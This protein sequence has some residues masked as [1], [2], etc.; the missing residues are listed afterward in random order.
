MNYKC[1]TNIHTLKKKGGFSKSKGI[2]LPTYLVIYI[3]QP[4]IPP[5]HV[6]DVPKLANGKGLAFRSA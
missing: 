1:S 5:F 4:Q 3:F 2:F 6:D